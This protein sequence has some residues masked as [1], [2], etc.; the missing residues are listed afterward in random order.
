MNKFLFK[1]TAADLSKMLSILETIQKNVL[2]LTY[3]VDMIVKATEM[4]SHDQSLQKQVND[5]F[6][7]SEQ[8]PTD[9]DDK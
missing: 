2:Y 1:S 7:G 8:N 4:R 3:R 5:Y 6:D 9:L